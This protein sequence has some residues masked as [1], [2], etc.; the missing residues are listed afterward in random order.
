[1]VYIEEQSAYLDRL[2][3]SPLAPL[4]QEV[5]YDGVAAYSM[6]THNANEVAVSLIIC[7]KTGNKADAEKILSQFSK[8]Q[9]NKDSHWIY[10]N[11]IV[12]S[13]VCAVHKFGLS[14][15]WISG[16]INLTYSAATALDKKIKDTFRN[17][18]TG[19]YS[20]RGDYHQISVVYQFIAK[21]ESLNDARLNEMYVELWESSFPFA[22]DDFLNVM[23]LKAIEIAFIKKAMLN[24]HQFTLMNN[25]VPTFKK[26]SEIISKI[27][28]WTVIAV[29]T[30]ASFYLLDLLNEKS[31][32]YP[33]FSKVLFFLLS[34]SG[35]GVSIFWGWKK[36]LSK[37]ILMLINK[38]FGFPKE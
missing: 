27:I 14:T 13:I 12:F 36:G 2:K 35:F 19:N 8:R 7:V 29:I 9:V 30:I 31:K 26:R 3:L 11:F 1:M 38:L 16:A 22:D 18:L 10:D 17:I 23:S 21:D 24:P 20:S 32:S 4:L 34:V 28:S 5:L 25:F 6:E 33:L 37:F 15:D